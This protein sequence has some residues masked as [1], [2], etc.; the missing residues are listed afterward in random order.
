M[1]EFELNIKNGMVTAKMLSERKE[2]NKYQ[3]S[4]IKSSLSKL[5]KQKKL[6]I[7]FR[8]KGKMTNETSLDGSKKFIDGK[9]YYLLY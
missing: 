9:C 4:T 5:K 3:I 2:L 6:R 8:T 7:G 1:K